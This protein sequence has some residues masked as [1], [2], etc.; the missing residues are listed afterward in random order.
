[1]H[2]YY[3]RYTRPRRRQARAEEDVGSL[4]RLGCPT[5]QGFLFSRAVSQ[6]IIE[7]RDAAAAIAGGD[8]ERRPAHSAPGEV[9]DL[10]GMFDGR[11]KITGAYEDVRDH[12]S[13]GAAFTATVR[14]QPVKGMVSC[15]MMGQAAAIAVVYARANATA[16]DWA[17]LMAAGPAAPPRP[18]D[19]EWR[20]K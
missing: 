20:A 4:R 9:G 17:K 16:D 10:A 7:L 6:P 3:P 1:M 11:P 5:G 18:H 8:L 2:Q 13:G 12:S 14:G 19:M 15:K